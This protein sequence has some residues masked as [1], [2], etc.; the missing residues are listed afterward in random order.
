MSNPIEQVLRSWQMACASFAQTSAA[1]PPSAET[2]GPPVLESAGSSESGD[3]ASD[4]VP[5][6]GF[7]PDEDDELLEQPAPT[8]AIEPA[9]TTTHPTPSL[10]AKRIFMVKPP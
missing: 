8:A 10:A 1:V 2:S 3:P 5:P 9:T 6:S 7:A 4:I